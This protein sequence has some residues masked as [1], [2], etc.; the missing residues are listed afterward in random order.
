M[1]EKRAAEIKEKVV[2]EE[3]RLSHFVIN[4]MA[5]EAEYGIRN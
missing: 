3:A 2:Q 5:D 1:N 4:K